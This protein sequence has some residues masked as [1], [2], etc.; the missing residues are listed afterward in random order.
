[1]EIKYLG[2]SCFKI[3]G[4]DIS[5]IIDPYD[6]SVGKKLGK[7]KCDVLLNTHQHK[8]HNNNADISDYRLLIENP[9]EYEIGGAFIYGFPTFHD[10][11]KGEERGQNTIFMIDLDG[12]TILHLGD[13]G[14]E[15]QK[16]TLEKLSGVDVLMIPVG[17]NYTIDSKVASKVVSQV[18]PR[19]VVP[20][21][22]KDGVFNKDLEIDK[23]A[24]F[25]EE[26]GSEDAKTEE[27]ITLTS[28]TTLPEEAEIVVL[29]A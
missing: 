28:T 13:L 17:G 22:Y 16:S 23:L 7:Q 11:K 4:K 15:L 19:I 25:L 2:H 8:D 3:K 14:H 5:L 21:H 1:M 10:N 26:M 18:E 27:K 20:M 29:S 12:F 24:K 9:G 6:E